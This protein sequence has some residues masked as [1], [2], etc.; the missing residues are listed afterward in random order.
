MVI[1]FINDIKFF[2]FVK[3]DDFM[4]LIVLVGQ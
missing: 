1:T 2:I 3:F 4:Y